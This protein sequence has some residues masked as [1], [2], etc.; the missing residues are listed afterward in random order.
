LR[1]GPRLFGGYRALFDRRDALI[2]RADDEHIEQDVHNEA[3]GQQ[4][5]RAPV[6]L[7][8]AADEPRGVGVSH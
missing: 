4:Y 5:H 3:G 8:D 7:N 2:Q 6:L 1:P